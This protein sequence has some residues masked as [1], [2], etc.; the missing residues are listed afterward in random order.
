MANHYNKVRSYIIEDLFS[1]VQL[2]SYKMYGGIEN[3]IEEVYKSDADLRGIGD[4]L[5]GC[6]S[7]SIKIYVYYEALKFWTI[8][9]VYIIM[10]ELL[11]YNNSSLVKNKYLK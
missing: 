7:H 6:I 2:A 10:G 11:L 3:T 1:L 8:D 5:D 9:E 4:W